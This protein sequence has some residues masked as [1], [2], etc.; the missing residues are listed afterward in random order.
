M[1]VPVSQSAVAAGMMRVMRVVRVLGVFGVLAAVG[2]AGTDAVAFM[3][4]TVTH[5]ILMVVPVLVLV[6]CVC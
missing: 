4:V 2:V 3:I 5:C 6:V 1:V